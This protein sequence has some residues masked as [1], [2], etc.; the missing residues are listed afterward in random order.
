VQTRGGTPFH[1]VE[2]RE[3]IPTPADQDHPAVAGG[4]AVWVS[5]GSAGND[6]SGGS[7]QGRFLPRVGREGLLG[8]WRG[9]GDGADSSGHGYHATLEGGLGFASGVV[10]RAFAL[11]G[12]DD[13]RLYG[14]ALTESE[15]RYLAGS[16]GAVLFADGFEQGDP[17]SWAVG[18]A[19]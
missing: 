18:S 16:R 3:R 4:M 17:L 9:E 11:D 8:W 2:G 7:I 13:L 14:R 1:S 10:G 6:T 19:R 12:V 5:Q 15:V